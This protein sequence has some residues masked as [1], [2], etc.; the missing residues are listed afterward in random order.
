MYNHFFPWRSSYTHTFIQTKAT[1]GK[2]T[3]PRFETASVGFEPRTSGFRDLRSTHS[4]TAPQVWRKH[5]T[6][7]ITTLRK[8]TY[9]HRLA[10]SAQGV[11]QQ[12][13]Q[14]R[15]SIRHWNSSDADTLIIKLQSNAHIFGPGS[16]RLRCH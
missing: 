13:C 1:W 7:R 12:L 15:L 6:I 2:R 3:C 9:H 8:P 16:T 14:H 4:A 5:T 11:L 10:V